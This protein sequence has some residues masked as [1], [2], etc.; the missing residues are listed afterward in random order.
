VF[1]AGAGIPG[2]FMVVVNLLGGCDG[3]NMVVPSHLSPYVDRRA[4]LNLVNETGS[5]GGLP[6]GETLHDLD[7]NWKLHYELANLKSIWDDNDL[8]VVNKVSYPQPNQSHFTSQDIYSYGVRDSAGDGDGR[9]WLGRFAD[10][11]CAN[12]VEPLG[13]VS[14]GLGRRVDFNSE[15]TQPVILNDVPGFTVDADND[16]PGNQQHRLNAVRD[17]LDT[18]PVPTSEPQ[19]SIFNTNRLAYD[20]VDRVAQG[21]A[22][23]DDP[24]LQTGGNPDGL[25]PNTRLGRYLRTISQLLSGQDDF[26]TKVF[27]TGFG[28]FDTHSSQL[29]RHANLMAQLDGAVG[30]FATDMKNRNKWNDCVLVVISEFGRRIFENGSVG[31]DHGHGNAFLVMG[32][33]VK[34]RLDVGSGMTAMPSEPDLQP[35]NNTVPFGVDFRDIYLDVID[36]HLGIDASTAQLFPDPDFSK[37][38]AGLG[39]V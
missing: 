14:V 25:Y 22:G 23:W 15:T 3:L 39:L 18:D 20:L 30:A 19:L 38:P 5:G 8:H 6:P 27:Y 32:G 17:V 29:D 10:E 26:N 13:V 1:G 24:G 31:T 36:G 35:P 7:G 28:G 33:R 34:G 16:F 37:D 4:A 21:V 2:R 9:G 11:F 12:P